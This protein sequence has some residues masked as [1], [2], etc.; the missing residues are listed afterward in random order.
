MA[1]RSLNTAATV[2]PISL[3]EAKLHLRVDGND[4][5]TLIDAYIS[6]ATDRVEAIVRRKLISQVWDIYLD[7]FPD[8]IVLPF[9][10]VVSIGTFEYVDQDGA[11]QTVSA[12]VY[13]LVA[14]SG[15]RPDFAKIIRKPDQSWP[16]ADARE[17]AVHI[18]AT[19]GYG[20]AGSNVPD[21]IRAAIMQ[22]VGHLYQNREPVIVGSIASEIPLTT[23]Y[24]LNPYRLFEFA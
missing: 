24:L 23:R 3:A 20:A 21:A 15:T 1:Y 13:E 7:E 22:L 6:A 12:S 14:P 5:D 18:R 10:P 16:T 4:D 9:S 8:E 19:F 2:R 11:T 17:N